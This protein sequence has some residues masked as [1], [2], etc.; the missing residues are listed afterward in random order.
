MHTDTLTRLLLVGILLCLIVLVA[1]GFGS[2][3]ASGIGGWG[4]YQV[5]GMRAGTPVLSA[6]A[7]Q[8][9]WIGETFALGLANVPAGQPAALVLGASRTTW[10]PVSLP[11]ALAFVGMP[12]CSLLVSLD[13]VVPFATA[14]GMG[15]L[16]LAVPNQVSLLGASFYCQGKAVDPPANPLGVIASNALGATVGQK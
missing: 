12:G 7:G 9:P 10:G 2:G 4:R 6:V 3:S 16:P 11:L 5:M 8:R 14:T 13:V 15:T 1:Q